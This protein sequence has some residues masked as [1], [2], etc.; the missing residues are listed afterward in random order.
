MKK[1]KETK[2]FSG[3]IQFI[4]LSP[5]GDTEGI[6]LD[7]GSFIKVPPHSLTANGLFKVGDFISG[8][9]EVVNMTPNP[10]IHH[11]KVMQGRKV[12]A[13]DSLDK[14]HRDAM[15]EQHRKDINDR[16]ESPFIQVK[17]KG[18]VVAVG[19]KPNHE[20]DRLIFADGTSVHI[21]KDIEMPTD[22]IDIGDMF[23]VTGEAR[24]FDKN[25]FLKAESVRAL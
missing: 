16:N 1:V 21:S 10:V 24:M 14:Q 2:E 7:D 3:A 8:S 15:R 23:E 12:L 6:V 5:H 22:E 20:V 4:S 17:I 25:R 11:A 19:T 13:D 9:G 18:K